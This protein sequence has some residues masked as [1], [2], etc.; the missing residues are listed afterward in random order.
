MIKDGGCDLAKA[1]R[2]LSK[3]GFPSHFGVFRCNKTDDHSHSY[4]YAS[5][6]W[7]PSHDIRVSYSNSVVKLKNLNFKKNKYCNINNLFFKQIN[8]PRNLN[9][10]HIRIE[11]N[12]G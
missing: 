3:R 7:L 6:T 10:I 5:N 1:V 2:V 11:C 8:L 4:A 9:R 12:S